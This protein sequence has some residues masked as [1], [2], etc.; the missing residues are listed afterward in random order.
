MGTLLPDL[1][2]IRKVPQS[3]RVSILFKVMWSLDH[4]PH[5]LL[6][7]RVLDDAPCSTRCYQLQLPDPGSYCPVQLT[8]ICALQVPS[9]SKW[10]KGAGSR[11]QGAGSGVDEEEDGR[12]I[13]SKGT[14]SNPRHQTQTSNSCKTQNLKPL[15]MWPP[16]LGSL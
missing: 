11:E 10:G 1:W 5:S 4:P 14:G 9:L 8:R 15:R 7:L 2:W 16:L 13:L 12:P 6:Q 3:Q